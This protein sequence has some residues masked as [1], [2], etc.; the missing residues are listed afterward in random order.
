MHPLGETLAWT[1]ELP[2]TQPAEYDHPRI[3]GLLFAVLINRRYPTVHG[4]NVPI[5]RHEFPSLEQTTHAPSASG[6]RLVGRHL[7]VNPDYQSPIR[8]GRSQVMTYAA[9]THTLVERST[10]GSKHAENHRRHRNP[11]NWEVEM[12]APPD[13]T[14]Q[15][16]KG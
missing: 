8:K 11:S 2:P 15:R 6:T 13:S 16:R 3:D 12:L 9:V 4:M 10:K 7:V 14:A 1:A 5:R